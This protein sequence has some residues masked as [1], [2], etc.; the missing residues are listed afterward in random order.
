MWLQLIDPDL[1][2]PAVR[3]HVERQLDLVAKG[4]AL[5]SDVL[6]QCLAEFK[7]K[8]GYFSQNVRTAPVFEFV[9]HIEGKRFQLRT[10]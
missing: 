3:G 9:E 4:A 6:E 1:C 2:L 7:L 5:F 10:D 8:F